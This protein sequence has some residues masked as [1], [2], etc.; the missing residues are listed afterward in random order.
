MNEV[1]FSKIAMAIKTAYPNYKLLPDK[2]SIDIWF[3]M[4]QDINYSIA[5]PAILEYIST[6][7]FPP[8][9]ADIREKCTGYMQLPIKDWGEAWESVINAIRKFGYMQ[10]EKALYSMDELTQKC[11]KRIGFIN[12]CQSENITADRAN[13]RMIYEQEANRR[14]TDNQLPYNLLK[15]KKQMVSML[16]ENVCERL[17]GNQNSKFNNFP[18]RTYD[19]DELEKQLIGNNK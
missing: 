9:I 5:Q 2:A 10:E 8:S 14:R 17:E 18:Q 13:F 11:V 19:F 4:L 7:K 15:Q 12:I 1:E 16:D 3:M 6:N